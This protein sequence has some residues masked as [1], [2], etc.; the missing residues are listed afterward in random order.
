MSKNVV[1]VIEYFGSSCL[2]CPSRLH[3]R[4]NFTTVCR[5]I[6]LRGYDAIHDCD[7]QT[8]GQTDGRTVRVV[9]LV[10]AFFDSVTP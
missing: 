7:R 2:W 3:L 8:D 10:R 5:M 1:C 6:K 4:K 9:Q